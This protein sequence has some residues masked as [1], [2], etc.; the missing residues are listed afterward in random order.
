MA[1]LL[2]NRQIPP[3]AR[4]HRARAMERSACAWADSICHAIRW[5]VIDYCSSFEG[6]IL[7]PSTISRKAQG[8][9]GR[10]LRKDRQS[11][12]RKG[13]ALHR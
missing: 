10:D 7:W 13:T 5:R 6:Y 9:S 2:L 12:I 3:T 11:E 4:S 8:G 1:R